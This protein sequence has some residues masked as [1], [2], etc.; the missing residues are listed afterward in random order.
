[1]K[2]PVCG[3]KSREWNGEKMTLEYEHEEEFKK[4]SE[5]MKLYACPKCDVVIHDSW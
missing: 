4:I 2:C 3:H 1:M 5:D